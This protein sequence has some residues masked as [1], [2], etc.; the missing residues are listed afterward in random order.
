MKAGRTTANLEQ[1][2]DRAKAVA[3]NKEIASFARL[4][5]LKSAM[6]CFRTAQEKGWLNTHTFSGIINAHV[7][8]GDL[9]GA[10]NMFKLLRST[11]TV[12]MDVIS[13]TTM[14]KGYCSVGDVSSAR[15]L[16][17][18]MFAS[19][20]KISP[21]IRTVNTFLRGC[22]FS[23]NVEDSEV[24]LGHCQRTF[25]L[26]PDVSSWEYVVTLLCQ[27]LCIDKVTPIIGRLKGDREMSS[28]MANMYICLARS[29][30]LLGNR[31]QCL[32]ALRGATDLLERSEIET[33]QRELQSNEYHDSNNK[34]TSSNEIQVTGGKRAWK[35]S[36][37]VHS[38][39]HDDGGDSAREQS[40]EIYKEHVRAELLQEVDVIRN[41]FVSR[42]QAFRF[43]QCTL[44]HLSQV[45]YFDYKCHINNDNG[46][47]TLVS[48]LFL[49]LI[50]KFGLLQ[51]LRH[52]Y[53][54]NGDAIKKRNNIALYDIHT[55]E[56]KPLS[57]KLSKEKSGNNIIQSKKKKKVKQILFSNVPSPSNYWEV[58]TDISLIPVL[59]KLKKE[60]SKSFDS[61][62][63]FDFNELFGLQKKFSHDVKAGGVSRDN[64]EVNTDLPVY[65]EVCSGAGEWVV[66]QAN[67]NCSSRWLSLELRHDRIYKTFARAV[68]QD[69]PN[70]IVLGGDA[71]EIVPRHFRRGS[72]AGAFVN[73]PEPPQ[74]GGTDDGE[75]QGKHLLTSDFMATVLDSLQDGGIFT[76]L[77]DNVWYGKMLLRTLASLHLTHPHTV[78]FSNTLA[79]CEDSISVELRLSGL[80]LFKGK[81]NA[82]CGHAVEASSYF[83]R[84]W[85]RD[86]NSDRYFIS[87]CTSKMEG[88]VDSKMRSVASL[89][90]NRHKR[91]AGVI[92]TS[93]VRGKKKKFED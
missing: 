57:S 48:D 59:E 74:Q 12:R 78:P 90:P 37:A 53:L 35:S 65:L 10:E 52:E 27:N 16:L 30:A 83:D 18:T 45:F 68:L 36:T 15:D 88:A 80:I 77:T 33:I 91:A 56:T 31:K 60:Y 85:K 79:E 51:L 67:H 6:E 73:Y 62:G 17:E 43:L 47:A 26:S 64:E 2:V 11:K 61:Q 70:L 3:L 44:S 22:L 86:K 42:P 7:R 66:D 39:E 38:D 19:N 23:G 82:S 24:L 8:C 92:L 32:K 81:P 20:P 29:Q 25:G 76:I 63:K 13:C 75:S 21:N 41:F 5:N 14:L 28:G 72:L 54:D 69:C 89:Q 50:K 93:S 1:R 40:L 58:E 55:G 71:T 87:L 84:L 34:D 9:E 49:S 46:V 4:K